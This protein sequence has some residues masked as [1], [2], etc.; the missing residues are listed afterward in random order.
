VK[1]E[2]WKWNIKK[3]EFLKVVIRLE[4]IKMEEEKMKEVL[5]WPTPKGFQDI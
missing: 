1:L 4:E 5:D 3:V 2:K